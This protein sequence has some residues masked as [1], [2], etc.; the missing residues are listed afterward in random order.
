MNC[1]KLVINETFHSDSRFDF[2]QI[3]FNLLF[4]YI[5]KLIIYPTIISK[6]LICITFNEVRMHLC[7]NVGVYQKVKAVL[8]L[9][10][11]NDGEGLTGG[12]TPG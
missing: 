2:K 11:K 7:K 9:G 5:S 10:G 12:T 4:Q 1:S 3:P 8:K 6:C